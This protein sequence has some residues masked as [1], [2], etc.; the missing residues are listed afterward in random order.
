ML[1]SR[2]VAYR[3]HLLSKRTYHEN[4]THLRHS[5]E[6]RHGLCL[7]ISRHRPLASEA[8]ANGSR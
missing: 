1:S 5:D 3:D 8:S 4:K 7:R 2:E 6:P